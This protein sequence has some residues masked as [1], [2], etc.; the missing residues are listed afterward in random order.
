MRAAHRQHGGSCRKPLV[1]DVD[2]RVRVAPELERDQREQDGL[3][4]A[5]RPDHQHV[6]DITDMGRQAKRGRSRR[7]GMEQRWPDRK[8]VV[9]GKSVSVRVDLGGGRNLKKKKKQK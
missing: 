7:A 8:S 3:A 9:W 1:E 4:G 2:L 5:G 6:P